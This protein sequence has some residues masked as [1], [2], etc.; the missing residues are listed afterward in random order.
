VSI[1]EAQG[2]IRTLII[3]DEK[4]L[5]VAKQPTTGLNKRNGETEEDLNPK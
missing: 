3:S 1:H 2:K 4:N 5:K